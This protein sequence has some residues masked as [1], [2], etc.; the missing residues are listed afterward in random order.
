MIQHIIVTTSEH[1]RA[2]LHM[3]GDELGRRVNHIVIARQ[4]AG[5]LVYDI[6]K[7]TRPCFKLN[8]AGLTEKQLQ[9]YAKEAKWHDLG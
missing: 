8:N 1:Y 2:M 4:A 9:Q 6:I 7:T 3:M 5:E